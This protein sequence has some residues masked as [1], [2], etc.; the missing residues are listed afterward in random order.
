MQRV[1]LISK[2][3]YVVRLA[4]QEG[5]GGIVD[6]FMFG[7]IPESLG[8]RVISFKE[9]HAVTKKRLV[10]SK[11]EINKG[12]LVQFQNFD[13]PFDVTKDNVRKMMHKREVARRAFTRITM[14]EPGYLKPIK[15]SF[16][17]MFYRAP[18]SSQFIVGIGVMHLLNGT[19]LD[20]LESLQLLDDVTQ[21]WQ[22]MD[23]IALEER[24]YVQSVVDSVHFGEDI[25]GA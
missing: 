9:R 18:A 13:V 6:E 23:E 7:T 8:D 15:S 11:E 2:H 1:R 25:A 14:S 5:A 21:S 16:E 3:D 17:G 22:H 4:K 12:T 20:E 19:L 10:G 24:A